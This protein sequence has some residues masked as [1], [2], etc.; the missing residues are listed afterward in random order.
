MGKSIEQ[1]EA[2]I[3][4]L[5]KV[6]EERGINSKKTT[7]IFGREVPPHARARKTPKFQT[8]EP[9][10]THGRGAMC[11]RETPAARHTSMGYPS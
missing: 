6:L 8:R 9:M 10:H 3:E 5:H 4:A 11:T 1:L 7:D 2:D